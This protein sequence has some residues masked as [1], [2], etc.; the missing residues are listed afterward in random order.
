MTRRTFV[1]APVPL[2]THSGAYSI[3]PAR[4]DGFDTYILRDA[5]H[6]T[7][8]RIAPGFGHNAYSMTVAGREFFHRPYTTLAEWAAKP[9]L[10]G[11]PLLWPWANRIDGYSYWAGGKQYTLNKELGNL[12]PDGN[13][14]PI[15]GLLQYWPNWKVEHAKADG[16]AAELRSVVEFWREPALAAQFPFAHSIHMTYRLSG[17]ALEVTTEI[18]N[19]SSTP[20]PVCLG[21]HPYFKLPDSARDTWQ[22]R[23]PA[24][25][26]Y[27]LSK[28]TVPNGET[29]PNSRPLE[30]AL[31]GN[32]VD[33]VFDTLTRDADGWARFA[34]SAGSERLTVEYGEAFPVAVVYA[35][36]GREFICFEPMT[37][38]TN[39]FNAAH[40]GWYKDLPSVAPGK[41]WKGV[42]RIRPSI[43]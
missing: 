43:G 4:A 22:V 7:E 17:G 33:D 37:A 3:E 23:L 30:F 20:L 35:P 5:A 6:Q 16:S 31:A 8:V 14:L 34:V 2:M 12:R 28:L 13:G 1:L 32:V 9:T 24:K 38:I 15:H 11:N 10:G 36:K 21:F 26:H 40:E 41:T 25:R 19:L 42:Y 27:K 39:A 18:D 29:E